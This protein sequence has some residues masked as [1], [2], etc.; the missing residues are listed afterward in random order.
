MRVLRARS[1]CGAGSVSSWAPET[2]ET[3]LRA[4][5][6]MLSDERDTLR[7]MIGATATRLF[8][9]CPWCGRWAYGRTCAEHRD[10]EEILRGE[11]M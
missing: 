6:D 10:V 5:I 1:V 9:R 3:R 4:R 8:K 11:V 2:R 7:Q